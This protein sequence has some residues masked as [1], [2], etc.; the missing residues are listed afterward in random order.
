LAAIALWCALAAARPASDL[1]Q[2]S[3][4]D[5]VQASTDYRSARG[6]G[7]TREE[8][9]IDA[10]H[11]LVASIRT[12]LK[13]ETTIEISQ[14]DTAVSQSASSVNRELTMME[15]E[16]LQLLDLPRRGGQYHC[17]AYVNRADL[18]ANMDRQ[19]QRIRSL[20]ADART[21]MAQAH[22]DVAL[23]LLYWAWLRANTVDTLVVEL[24]GTQAS[25]PR[26]ALIEALQGLVRGVE[27]QAGVL[28]TTSGRLG[29]AV[30]A[31]YQGRPATVDFSLYTGA[32]MEYPHVDQG[33]GYVELNGDVAALPE[34][35]SA[36]PVQLLYAYE[37]QMMASPD[38]LALQEALGQRPLDTYV[39]L[40]LPAAAVRQDPP[41]A[42]APNRAV[43]PPAPPARAAAGSQAVTTASELSTPLA[44]RVL[45]EQTDAEVFLEAMDILVRNDRLGYFRQQPPAD[46]AV[47]YAAVLR[48]PQVVGVYRRC[49]DGFVEVRRRQH[50]PSLDLPAFA[51]ARRA[52]LVPTPVAV[53]GDLG[54]GGRPGPVRQVSP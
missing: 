31:T 36:L 6:I 37:G 5:I 23:R 22:L 42:A 40:H 47:V 27:L 26:D 39:A 18:Q 46:V 11:Q 38:L 51:G 10:R 30:T 54:S 21:A 35:A 9:R 12:W 50:V 16:G 43:P 44:I 29:F 25:D 19:R 13:V 34:G 17:L 49:A 53:E 15:L 4:A 28:D 2:E 8:A 7:D 41:P 33:R 48:P 32:G 52:W 1:A 20:V 24:P 14:R 3:Q 45:A